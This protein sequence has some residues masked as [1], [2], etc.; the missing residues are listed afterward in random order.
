MTGWMGYLIGWFYW[1]ANPLF[2]ISL[3]LWKKPKA[4]F[5]LSITS[6]VIA[7]SFIFQDDMILNEGG[8]ADPIQ[9]FSAGYYL[10]CLSILSLVIISALRAFRHTKLDR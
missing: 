3:L 4:A 1:T 2:L 5:W 8:G 6:F 7:I 9:S 10:W